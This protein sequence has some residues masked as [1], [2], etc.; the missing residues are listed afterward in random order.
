MVL[1]TEG[2]VVWLHLVAASIW[3]GGSIFIG[4]I[5]SPILNMITRTVEERII[6]L[7]KIGRRFSYI[8]I[9]SFGVLVLTGIYNSKAFLIDPST[10][11]QTNYGVI[12]LVKISLVIATLIAYIIHIRIINSETETRIVTGNASKTF[13][14]SIRSRTIFLGRTIV[15]L[16]IMILLLAAFLDVGG[17]Y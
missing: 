4:V 8:A 10:L 17:L 1:L 6:I 13:V 5:L 2:L 3:V 14:Q 11:Y 7:I 16:S 9:P 12:L 15:I